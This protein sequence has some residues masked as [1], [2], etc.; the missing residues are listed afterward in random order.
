ME[1]VYN[2]PEL[3]RYLTLALEMDSQHPVLIDKY[4]R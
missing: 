4:F 3:I 2:E 1:I